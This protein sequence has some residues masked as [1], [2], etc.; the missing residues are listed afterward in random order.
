VAMSKPVSPDQ[1][2]EEPRTLRNQGRRTRTALL[3]A[4]MVAL[5][6]KGYHAARVDDVV[7]IAGVSHGTFYLYFSSKEDLFGAMAERCATDMTTLAGEL[8]SI[9]AAGG[10]E[11]ALR[12][13]LRQFLALYRTHGVVI[14]AWAE[15][16]VD[17]HKLMAL[18][19]GSFATMTSSFERWIAAARPEGASVVRAAAMLA[20]V[21]RF[22]YVVT[23]RD[24]GWPDDDILDTL[25]RL[26]SRAFLTPAA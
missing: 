25:T 17:D 8:S 10:D 12:D 2:P 13:W 23:S 3:D 16:H 7:R 22:A 15:R 26:I 11:A 6:E 14:R 19:S 20:L 5:S 9:P 24:L 18:G 21:E 1:S 4:A